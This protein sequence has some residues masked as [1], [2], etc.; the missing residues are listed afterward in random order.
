M[1][2]TYS[3]ATPFEPNLPSA[4]SQGNPSQGRLPGRPGNAFA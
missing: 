4:S 2:G 3:L 1:R